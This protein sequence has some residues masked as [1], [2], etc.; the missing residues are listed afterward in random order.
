MI[1][2][3]VAFLTGKL[4]DERTGVILFAETIIE[5]VALVAL[6]IYIMMEVMK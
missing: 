4:F 5:V 1:I 6:A 2:V 3:I